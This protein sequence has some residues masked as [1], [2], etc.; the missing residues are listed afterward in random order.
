MAQEVA[1]RKRELELKL[2][3]KA[4]LLEIN[5]EN[6]LRL[7]WE[8]AKD[9]T[10]KGA[11]KIAASALLCKILGI[12]HEGPV[13]QQ[14]FFTQVEAQPPQFLEAQEDKAE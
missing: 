10:E 9:R 7:N 12:Y 6:I 2:K 3:E 4:K 8:I 14:A 5:K 1:R 11:N 13:V